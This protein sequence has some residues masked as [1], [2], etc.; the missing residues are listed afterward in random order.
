LLGIIDD[1]V[2]EFAA[3]IVE[4]VEL[5]LR[6]E[7]ELSTGG[8]TYDV[9]LGEVAEM[10]ESLNGPVVVALPS[11]I[12]TLVDEPKLG[13]AVGSSSIEVVSLNGSLLG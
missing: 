4:Y 11:T 7:V 10:I 1:T 6:L 8:T 13:L 9:L 12:E 2:L 5:L 3:G